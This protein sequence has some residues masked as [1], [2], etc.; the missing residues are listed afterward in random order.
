MKGVAV[1]HFLGEHIKSNISFISKFTHS[2]KL[3]LGSRNSS[4]KKPLEVVRI[5]A[6]S[7]NCPPVWIKLQE[8]LQN[9]HRKSLHPTR[10]SLSSATSGHF[11]Q[12]ISGEEMTNHGRLTVIHHEMV[13]QYFGGT[14][15]QAVNFF[16]I[17]IFSDSRN[18]KDLINFY[19]LFTY[20]SDLL[21]NSVRQHVGYSTPFR[22][23]EKKMDVMTCGASRG[24]FISFEML[25]MLV[26]IIIFKRSSPIDQMLKYGSMFVPEVLEDEKNGFRF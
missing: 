24:Q 18:Q 22:C 7:T 13:T 23:H 14:C 11:Q 6:I 19:C 20:E 25:A 1:H 16:W 4:H 17:P 8:F 15:S 12:K 10:P 26:F 2:V 9:W 5:I 21:R 3:Y